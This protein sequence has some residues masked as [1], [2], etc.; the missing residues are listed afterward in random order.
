METLAEMRAAS[1]QFMNSLSASAP[2]FE[3]HGA[4]ARPR[5]SSVEGRGTK[6]GS[7]ADRGAAGQREARRWEP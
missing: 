6:A 5:R 7:R 3:A 4:T 2:S 1:A